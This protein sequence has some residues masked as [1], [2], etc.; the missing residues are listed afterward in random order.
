MS[1]GSLFLA[2]LAG[3]HHREEELR[4]KAI[5]LVQA[6][7]GLQLHLAIVEASMDLADVLRRLDTSD[8]D[9]KVIKMLGMRSFNAFGASLKLTL[10]GYS[11]NSTLIL[12]DVMET[13]FLI[14]YFSGDRTLIERWRFANKKTL[15]KDFGPVKVREA[16]DSRDGFSGKKRSAMYGMFSE[17]A[18]HPNMKSVLMMRPQ[19]D[20]DAV[21]GPFMEAT[22]LDAV[23]SEMGRLAFQA[24][25]ALDLFFPAD[26]TE[27][28]QSR[29]AFA[30]LK[31]HWIA[32]FYSTVAAAPG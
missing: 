17:L 16:L 20:G 7:Q 18:V 22:T 4:E 19:R 24:G 28:L 27:G 32:T 3:L 6:D 26:W 9:L 2:K 23:I 15:M 13:V 12:R 31:R 10:S 8:E 30:K 5:D 14:D 21:I 1:N 11:Q 29:L 25:E